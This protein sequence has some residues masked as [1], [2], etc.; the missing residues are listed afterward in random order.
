MGYSGVAQAKEARESLGSALEALQKDDNIPQDVLAVAQNIAQAVGALFE[1]ERASSEPDGKSSVRSA[2]GSLS[3]T[4]ALL[5]DVR[6]EHPG[7]AVATE[8]IAKSMSSL[9]PLTTVPSKAPSARP[10]NA[11][12]PATAVPKAAPVPVVPA[13]GGGTA[14]LSEAQ[15]GQA[16]AA[17]A[18]AP[19]P[20]G[21]LAREEVEANIGA[22]TES[23]FYVGFSGEIS[24]GG[25]FLATY[26]TFP[27]GTPINMLVTLPGGFE[28][29]VTGQVRFVRDPLDFSADSE[30]GMGIQFDALQANDRELV[31]RFIRKRPPMFYD[32]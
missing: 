30:P 25:V 32:D 24:E 15:K 10:S 14:P 1:A 27:R 19:A 12:Q 26:E 8:V 31:L 17:S 11:A 2:L 18:P 16:A 13:S 5:Q 4:L 3:Q 7:I 22:T 28:M 9:Y 29:R 23:N 6:G 21:N 20:A